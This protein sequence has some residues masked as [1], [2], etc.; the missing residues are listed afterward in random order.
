MN[1]IMPSLGILIALLVFSPLLLADELSVPFIVEEAC[2]FEGCS[3]GTWKVLK[4]TFVYKESNIE[5]GVVN[6]LISGTEVSIETGVL[7]VIPGKAQVTGEPYKTASAIK[8]NEVIYILDYIGEGYSRVYHDGTFYETKV[9]R[10]KEQCSINHNWRYC[11]VEVLEEP[12]VK[13][14]VKVQGVG[15]VLMEGNQLKPIDAFASLG[16]V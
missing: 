3:F 6:K 1:R 12:K 13:W 10:T 15:W 2:P 16:R 4:N 11:W 14:W 9:A 7:Y 5:S 8:T